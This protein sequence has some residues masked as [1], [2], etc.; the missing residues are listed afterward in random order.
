MSESS[1][2]K[3]IND[4][5]QLID[6]Q[7]DRI[8]N[9]LSSLRSLGFARSTAKKLRE[10]LIQAFMLTTDKNP[11]LLKLLQI[12]KEL[13]H[14][15]HLL[16]GGT[17]YCQQTLNNAAR[18]DY[19]N[20]IICQPYDPIRI[21]T[22]GDRLISLC[23][24]NILQFISLLENR[25]NRVLNLINQPIELMDIEISYGYTTNRIDPLER[26]LILRQQPGAE[27]LH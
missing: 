8:A 7:G 10:L 21:V 11:E 3:L 22:A 5:Q 26:E 4:L 12:A 9:K 27:S 16:D 18:K 17:D 13:D 25:L 2:E 15:N 14:Q 23:T 19:L 6:E 20:L 1:K 24:D